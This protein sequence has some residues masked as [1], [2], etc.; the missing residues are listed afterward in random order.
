[1]ST[2]AIANPFDAPLK[3]EM[4]E[5]Q[6]QQAATPPMSTG[7]V[8]PFDAPLA[9]ER[10]E[11]D[12][13]DAQIAYRKATAAGPYVPADQAEKAMGAEWGDNKAQAIEGAKNL[14]MATAA[15]AGGVLGVSAVDTA[16]PAL[17]D[18]AVAHLNDLTKVVR[19]ARA[20]G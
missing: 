15:T 17:Y 13:T 18:A 8:N 5:G 11:T 6:Q 14:G 10:A 4:Q 9:S 1:M 19:A 16:V 12:P 7:V 3:S 20:R 2:G